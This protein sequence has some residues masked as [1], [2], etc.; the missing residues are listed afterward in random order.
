[1]AVD[2]CLSS[3]LGATEVVAHP[4]IVDGEP[5]GAIAG[6]RQGD[7][8]DDDIAPLL[9]VAAEYVSVAHANNVL[10]STV[11]EHGANL[12]RAL[13]RRGVIEQAKGMIMHAHGVSSEE[14]FAILRGESQH[15]NRK[16]RD[17]ALD[18]TEGRLPVE[19]LR[20]GREPAPCVIPDS[21][22]APS[23]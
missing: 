3:A 17:V 15:T 18:V 22:E 4:V 5:V 13:E 16:L 11:A 8:L 6:W 20:R 10:Y 12:E 1:V 21:V 2:R 9:A 19:G 7:E 14:A 23:S